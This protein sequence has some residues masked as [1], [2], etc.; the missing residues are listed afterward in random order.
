MVQC[1]STGDASYQFSYQ[2]QASGGTPPYSWTIL[3]SLGAGEFFSSDGVLMV[4]GSAC[5][6]YG[7]TSYS[8]RVDD[9]KG[10]EA[11]A[12]IRI[13]FLAPK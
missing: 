1:S 11:S 9:A 3:S 5:F 10:L 13:D 6:G 2:F 7:V 12:T 8:L 4:T